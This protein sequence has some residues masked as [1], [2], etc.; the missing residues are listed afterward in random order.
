[1][2]LISLGR[3]H[4]P[5]HL[6]CLKLPPIAGGWQLLA[7]APLLRQPYNA[8]PSFIFFSLISSLFSYSSQWAPC[9]RH[10]TETRVNLRF[11]SLPGAGTQGHI[12][13]STALKLG[14]NQILLL[15]LVA[16]AETGWAPRWTPGF[17]LSS[18]ID[19]SHLKLTYTHI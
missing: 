15:A 12:S 16:E 10:P 17:S 3:H 8:F 9:S 4:L 18:P 6:P 19:R 13:S 5:S 1:M 2:Q 14:E 7:D 11:P